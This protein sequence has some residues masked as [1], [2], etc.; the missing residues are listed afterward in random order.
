MLFLAYT[1]HR[2]AGYFEINPAGNTGNGT[3]TN[4]FSYVDTKGNTYVRAV[5]AALN[6]ITYDHQSGSLAPSTAPHFPGFPLEKLALGSVRLPGGRE[7]TI[8]I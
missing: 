3:N 7:F 8:L 6:N 2:A 5:G 1:L 4:T